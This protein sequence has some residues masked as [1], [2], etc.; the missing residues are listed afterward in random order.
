MNLHLGCSGW[1]YPDW[2]GVVY[3][4]NLPASKWFSHYATVFD[5]VEI[6][7]TFY[8]FPKSQTAENW[9]K[10]APEGFL[11]TL[12]APRL[13]TH[14]RRFND[15][16]G[17]LKDFYAACSVLQDK[18]GCVLFQLPPSLRFDKMKLKQ[19]LELLDPAFKNVLEFRHESWWCE[20]AFA[21]LKKHGTIFC[22]VS[23][24]RLPDDLITTSD[25]IYVRFHGAKSWYAYDYAKAELSEWAGKIRAAKP[26]AV[27]A[28]FNNDVSGF[29]VQNCVD[30]RR[31]LENPGL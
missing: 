13:I 6:N 16:T 2:K 15:C 24:P 30:L 23:A 11:Y 12:K 28:Y 8:H 10:R 22:S 29:A 20:E 9:R 4:E 1:S 5:T 3:P 31:M 7:Y 26:K 17:L 21:V 14:I 25:D 19:I 27:W 18:L